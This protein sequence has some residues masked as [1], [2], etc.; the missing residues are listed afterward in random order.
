ML[1]YIKVGEIVNFLLNWKGII[2]NDKFFIKLEKDNLGF[3][4]F[5]VVGVGYIGIR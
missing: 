3:M 2:G 1:Y 5:Y 4:D